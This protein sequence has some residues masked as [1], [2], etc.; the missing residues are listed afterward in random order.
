MFNYKKMKEFGI[1]NL[2]T[3][4]ANTLPEICELPIQ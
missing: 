3:S 4:T 2:N 1:I